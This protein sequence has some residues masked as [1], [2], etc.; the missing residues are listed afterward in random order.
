MYMKSMFDTEIL[1]E[2]LVKLENKLVKGSP[3][4]ADLVHSLRVAIKCTRA[5]LLVLEIPCK[6]K[7]VLDDIDRRLAALGKELS[8]DREFFVASKILQKLAKNVQTEEGVKAIKVAI[9]RLE[10]EKII[11]RLD[12]GEIAKKM[13]Q[14]IQ[15]IKGISANFPDEPGLKRHFSEYKK[16]TCKIGEKALIKQDSKRLHRWRKHIKTLYYQLEIGDKKF[17]KTGE[18]EKR[19]SKLGDELGEV[20]DLFDLADRLKRYEQEEQADIDF[21]SLL[22]LITNRRN[23]LLNKCQI[24]FEKFCLKN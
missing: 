17:R 15:K 16:R 21:T 12:A 14:S 18:M 11:I 22:E 7:P 20:H 1:T 13:Q 3:L 4:D 6:Q 2:Q 8:V 23:K 9:E 19:L 10:D 24:D 5:R